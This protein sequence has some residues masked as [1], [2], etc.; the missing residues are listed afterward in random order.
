REPAGE[1]SSR[2]PAGAARRISHAH[3]LHHSR[4]ARLLALRSDR[5]PAAVS[6]D[7]P[8]LR[9]H[10]RRHHHQF[11]LWRLAQCVWRRQDDNRAPRPPNPSLRDHRNRQRE[12]A[13]QERDALRAVLPVIAELCKGQNVTQKIVRAM[14]RLEYA[15]LVQGDSLVTNIKWRKALL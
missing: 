7:Q 11:G 8:A 15:L 12:L 4:R 3:G 6:S 9:A 10:F 14:V 5:R 2:Q 1:R 13:L